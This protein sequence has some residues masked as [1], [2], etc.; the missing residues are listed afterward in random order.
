MEESEG[1]ECGW[2]IVVGSCDF[3]EFVGVLVYEVRDED[4]FI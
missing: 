1:N 2:G 4:M 3:G